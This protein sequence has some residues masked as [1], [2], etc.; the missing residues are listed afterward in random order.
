M[1]AVRILIVVALS[2]VAGLVVGIPGASAGVTS[3]TTCSYTVSPTQL[4]APGTVEVAG[5]APGTTQVE[6][7]VDGVTAATVQS[8]PVTGEW[9]PVL[10]DIQATSVITIALPENYANLPCIGNSGTE[11][12][13]VTVG[14]TRANL[15]LTGSDTGR[16]A[17]VGLAAIG[18][19]TALVVGA[20]RRRTATRA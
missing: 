20:R 10:V 16:W 7:Q 5:I 18:L 12:V 6:V 14:R 2:A 11:V 8:E 3:G 19:G 15:P 13:R 17:F 4:E 1:R 9:G